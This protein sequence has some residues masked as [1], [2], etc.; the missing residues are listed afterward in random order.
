MKPVLIL[1]GADKGGVGKTTVCRLLLDYMTE[2]SIPVRAFDTEAPRGTLKRFYPD[3]TEVV[4]M[5]QTT[6]QMKIFDTL[7]DSDVRVSLVD[8]RAGQ[9]R[10]ILRALGEFGFLE[11]SKRGQFDFL[12]FHILGSSVASLEEIIETA[13][14]ATDAH[15]YLVKNVISDGT[16]F[17]WGP[18][19]YRSYFERIEGAVELTIPKLNDTAYEQ[20][21]YSGMPFSRFAED[22]TKS[23]VLRGYVKSWLQRAREQFNAANVPD[24]IDG[25]APYTDAPFNGRNMRRLEEVSE[26]LTERLQ[27]LERAL[28]D[29]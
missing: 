7:D 10:V 6:D 24:M 13:P 17:E 8:V 19:I 4:D 14:F 27:A 26:M 5:A 23:F 2:R 28:K 22:K 29:K 1:V 25:V 9:L 15:H 21:D 20:I 12:L 3:I 11:A 18:E 16:P